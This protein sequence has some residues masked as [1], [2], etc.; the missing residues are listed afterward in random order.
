MKVIQRTCKYDIKV[1]VHTYNEFSRV[2]DSTEIYGQDFDPINDKA[3]I[4]N[5]QLKKC[6]SGKD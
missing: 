2:I 6:K 5:Y 3:F 4:T 1:N